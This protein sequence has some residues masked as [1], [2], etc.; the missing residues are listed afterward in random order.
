MK[1]KNAF[2]NSLSFL[3]LIGI[4]AVVVACALIFLNPQTGLNPLPPP[5]L[6]AAIILPTSTATHIKLPPTWTPQGQSGQVGTASPAVQA[7]ATAQASNTPQPAY[8]IP[9]RTAT[10]SPTRTGTVTRT[11][12]KVVS[13]GVATRTITRTPTPNKTA[14]R[15]AQIAT[16]YKQTQNAAGTATV[17]AGMPPNPTSA[18]ETH[19]VISSEWTD[20]N[21]PSFTWSVPTGATAYRVYWGT[22]AS[23][24]GSTEITPAAYTPATLTSSG[25]YYL[26]LRTRFAAGLRPDWTTVF[27]YRFD[28]TAPSAVTSASASGVT[29]GQWTNVN[30]PAFTWSAATDTHSGMTGGEAGYE[31]YF[32]PALTPYPTPTPGVTPTPSSPVKVTEEEYSSGTPSAGQDNVLMI[33]AMDQ[34]GN[35]S[36]W[37][38]VFTYW[39][40]GTAPAV[41]TTP[42]TTD[43]PTTDDT[44]TFTWDTVTDSLSGLAAYEIY[45]GINDTCGDPNQSET[46]STSFTAPSMTEIAGVPYYLCVRTRDNAGNTS[47][48]SS[49]ADYTY[50]PSPP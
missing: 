4:L 24:T 35:G 21:N 47:G 48:W 30:N 13:V 31:V 7:S 50:S 23:G 41:P 44:P 16:Y 39:Y 1:M 29:S 34:V 37:Q 11:P 10:P 20:V 19:G 28:V 12:T 6:P 38:T 17:V 2:W 46:T 9:T 25:T 43:D 3:A 15:N 14:T 45:W 42:G 49:A 26:R 40:D 33:R 5:T 36:T 18:V 22:D 32:G 27:T 8:V